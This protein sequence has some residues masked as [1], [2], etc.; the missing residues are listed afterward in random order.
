MIK[1]VGWQLSTVEL[2]TVVAHVEYFCGDVEEKREVA[3]NTVGNVSFT[4]SWQTTHDDNEL[5]IYI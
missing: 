1:K 5:E 3:Y 4:R 2:A